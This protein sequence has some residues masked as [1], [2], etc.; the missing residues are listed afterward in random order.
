MLSAAQL[1]EIANIGDPIFRLTM[2]SKTVQIVRASGDLSYPLLN[3]IA[4]FLDGL[5]S[6]PRGNNRAQYPAYLKKHFPDLSDSL[7]AEIFYDHYRCAA[8]HEFG[9]GNGYAIGLNDGMDGEYVAK[10][11][12]IDTGQVLTILNI[13]RLAD[14]FLRHINSLLSST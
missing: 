12:I 6:A 10:Q 1:S 4:T 2:M 13:E 9:L 8:V 3:L 7:G 14:D 5:V 11:K